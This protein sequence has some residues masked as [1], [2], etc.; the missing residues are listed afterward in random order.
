MAPG[1]GTPVSEDTM[2]QG[3]AE[4][5]R[6]YDPNNVQLRIKILEMIYQGTRDARDD[7]E[8]LGFEASFVYRTIVVGRELLDIDLCTLT[9]PIMP[10]PLASWHPVVRL[11]SVL[12]QIIENKLRFFS[13]VSPDNAEGPTAASQLHAA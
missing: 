10:P 7:P 9:F 12:D 1:V 8:M 2:G 11:G 13:K 4:L 3:Y 5:A 6:M